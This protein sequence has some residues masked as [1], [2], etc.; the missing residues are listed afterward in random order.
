[1]TYSDGLRAWQAAVVR[2]WS[3][4]ADD[5][6]GADGDTFATLTLSWLPEGSRGAPW[7]ARLRHGGDENWTQDSAVSAAPTLPDALQALWGRAR[8]RD[9]VLQDLPDEFTAWLNKDE[10]TL[11]ERVRV[12]LE[13]RQPIEL[14]VYYRPELGL[15]TQWIALLH[16]PARR[17]PE[18]ILLTLYAG[19]LSRIFEL[20]LEALSS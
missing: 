11:L 18:G 15:S 6:N 9:R 16:D 10:S 2:L 8:M 4:S 3:Q 13:P 7:I 1:M 12:E 17:L 5:E 14:H 20:L 19:D